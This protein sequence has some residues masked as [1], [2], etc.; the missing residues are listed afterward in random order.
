MR[1]STGFRF[2]LLVPDSAL[3]APRRCA[4][5]GDC[6]LAVAAASASTSLT[7][8][9]VS[10]AS[11]LLSMGAC[12]GSALLCSASAAARDRKSVVQGQSVDLGGR[13]IIIKKM[14]RV[15]LV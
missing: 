10:F 14:N 4:G 7:L 1:S 5:S 8:G 13:R 3:T 2:A 11:A 9:S 12:A 6:R 15:D